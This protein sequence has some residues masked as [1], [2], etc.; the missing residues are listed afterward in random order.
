MPRLLGSL[1]SLLGRPRDDKAASPAKALSGRAGP[2][3]NAIAYALYET[4]GPNAEKASAYIRP[5]SDKPGWFSFE[6]S[7]GDFESGT[8]ASIALKFISFD[9]NLTSKG[10]IRTHYTPGSDPRFIL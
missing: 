8:A 10:Y 3:P 2:R 1:L 7:F 9:R 4:T 6:N 5:S